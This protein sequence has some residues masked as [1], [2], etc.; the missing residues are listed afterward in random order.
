AKNLDAAEYAKQNVQARRDQAARGVA[1]VQ[2]AEA[3]RQDL[4]SSRLDAA[5]AKFQQADQALPGQKVVT[6]GLAEIKQREDTYQRLKTAAEQD[7]HDNNFLAAKD[8]FEQARTA[9][10]ERFA[11]EGLEA[12]E[13]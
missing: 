4:Q 13:N 10:R 9:H 7:V 5:K 2:L 1:G 3:G 12:R 6:D 11:A 8:K